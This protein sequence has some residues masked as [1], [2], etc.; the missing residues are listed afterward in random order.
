MASNNP[1]LNKPTTGRD[2]TQVL[3]RSYNEID[4][5]I[6]TSGFLTSKVG[7]KV[8]RTVST[9]NTPDDTETFAFIDNGTELYTI[10]II[11]TDDTREDMISAE[12]IS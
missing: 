4:A 7:N 9:T 8:T 12:R 5:S 3:Q 1:K 2:F 10:K 11:Y 6:A